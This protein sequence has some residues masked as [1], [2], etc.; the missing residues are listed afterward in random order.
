MST[1][2]NALGYALQGIPLFPCD[3]NDKTPLCARGFHAATTDKNQIRT[4]WRCFPAAM[5]GLPCGSV[6]GLWVFDVDVDES[7][8]IDGEASLLKLTGEHGPLPET[9]I[10]ATPRGGRQYFFNWNENCGIRNSTSKIGVGLDVRGAGGYTIMPPSVRADGVAYRWV[11]ALAPDDAPQ[12]L[13]DASMKAPYLDRGGPPRA[14]QRVSPGVPLARLNG[15]AVG[16]TPRIRAWA[17]GALRIACDRIAASPAGKRNEVL[18][19]EAFNVFQLVGAGYLH[20]QEVRAR[21]TVAACACGIDADYG[22][23]AVDNTINSAASAGL[24]QPRYYSGR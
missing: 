12:W 5:I 22:E 1:L 23:R 14:S 10:S 21:L 19:S 4:W 13:I 9:R 20:E 16:D 18:N 2:P 7:K 24:A 15:A 11:N 17:T 3:P 6:S 8:G